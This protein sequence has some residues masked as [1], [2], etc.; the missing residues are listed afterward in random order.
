MTTPW[1]E[2]LNDA[3]VAS[4]RTAVARRLG[5]SR[6]AVSLVLAGKYGAKTT[7]IEAKVLAVIGNSVDCPAMGKA[8]VLDKCR[9]YHQA[10]AP[11]HNPIA[12]QHWR[13]CQR[14]PHN[15]SC[16]AKEAPDA[17]H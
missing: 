11:M 3:V 1:L 15:P 12:M 9:E 5:I 2:L 14:C 8:I 6:T 7:R 10:R 13:A 16:Q 4:N 17:R